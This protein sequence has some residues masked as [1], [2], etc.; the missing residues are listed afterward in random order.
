MFLWNEVVP[1]IRMQ[2]LNT[3]L[4]LADPA[5]DSYA[6]NVFGESMAGIDWQTG[7]IHFSVGYECKNL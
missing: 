1:V 3:N 2:A 6:C 5:Y 7:C 4:I